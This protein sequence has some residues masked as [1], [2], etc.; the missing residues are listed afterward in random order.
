[1]PV[2]MK[3]SAGHFRCDGDTIADFAALAF[4]MTVR[5]I[6]FASD[7]RSNGRA[8]REKLARCVSVTSVM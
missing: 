3:N 4:A 8:M 1:M 2:A 5:R 7:T 6:G